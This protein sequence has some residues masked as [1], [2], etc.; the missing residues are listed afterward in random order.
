MKRSTI[1]FLIFAVVL[2]ITGIILCV[3]GNAKAESE[4]NSMSISE[5]NQLFRQVKDSDGNLV[6]TINLS[7]EVLNKINIDVSEA[8]VNVYGNS[9][10]CYVQII[11][12]N[13]IEY[14]AY[15]NNRSFTIENDLISAMI[16]RVSGGD[17][18]YN[19]LRDYF[20]LTKSNDKKEINIYL[21][22][23]NDIKIF[24]ISVGEGDI[25]FDS[26]GT[27]SDYNINL[28][29]GNVTY[30]NTAEISKISASV[31]NG[32][33]EL[34]G[35][36]ANQGIIEIGSGDLTLSSPKDVSYSYDL[37]VE[38]GEIK[39]GEEIFK[40]SH[41]TESNESGGTFTANVEVGNIKIKF[42]E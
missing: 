37:T 25:N 17:I 41:K 15:T 6:E 35:L 7:D 38:V 21:T 13:A 9:D 39:I 36:F 23:Q 27:I 3:V 28:K 5:G 1:I 19:G 12:F 24:D 40:G 34:N 18:G 32:N 11:N 26:I 31:E 10:V 30:K 42:D 16:N 2:I 14:S 4:F 20:R 22:H 33:I 29:K 8:N